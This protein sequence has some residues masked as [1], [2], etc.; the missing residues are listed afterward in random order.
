MGFLHGS[1]VF[2]V[3]VYRFYLVLQGLTGFI[4]GLQA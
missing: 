3:V 2:H 4:H 1:I